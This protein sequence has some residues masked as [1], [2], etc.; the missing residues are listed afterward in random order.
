MPSWVWQQ[1][2]IRC[3]GEKPVV[4]S[5]QAW[6]KLCLCEQGEHELAL[7]H[8]NIH[9]LSLPLSTCV[10]LDRTPN[11]FNHLFLYFWSRN[12]NPIAHRAARK[13]TWDKTCIGTSMRGVQFSSVMQSC[14][15]LCD[16]MGT[17]P[18]YPSPTPG[19]YSNSCPLSRWCHPAISSSVVPFSGFRSF[20]ASGS[21]PVSQFFTSVRVAS[22]VRV[23]TI[24]PNPREWLVILSAGW[25][26]LAPSG[27]WSCFGFFPA[28]WPVST[29]HPPWFK[30]TSVLS[31]LKIYF[32]LYKVGGAGE[33]QPFSVPALSPLISGNKVLRQL[34]KLRLW[35]FKKPSQDYRASESDQ[36]SNADESCPWVSGPQGTTFHSTQT[37]GDP[38]PTL[39]RPT[40]G[41]LP[42][43]LRPTGVHFPLCL[44]RLGDPLP[45]RL[46]SPG[47]GVRF[48][49]CSDPSSAAF[50]S[51]WSDFIDFLGFPGGSA[52]I[53]LPAVLELWVPSLSGEDALEK[54][55]QP[56]PLFLPGKPMDRGAWCATVHGFTKSQTQLS[57]E[58]TTTV[59]SKL[60]VFYCSKLWEILIIR[61]EDI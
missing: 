7:S 21:F 6:S 16:P 13:I 26:C 59:L 10:V 48:P 14:P 39:L 8:T 36:D 46:R 38:P 23:A 5:A 45:L 9:I 49:L 18:P 61:K 30:K 12:D 58:T 27:F 35:Y 20:P 32:S 42:T 28:V 34:A 37:H 25:P 33:Q 51:L 50:M 41:P 22:I 47:G 11:V 2:V 56:T 4:L 53:N 1:C 40:G 57:D 15:T 60:S 31:T 3:G 19:A 44:G 24:P 55:M 17:R 29:L 52:V 54:E 43:L